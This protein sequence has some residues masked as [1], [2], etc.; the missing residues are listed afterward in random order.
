MSVD[1]MGAP[2][3]C[4]MRQCVHAVPSQGRSVDQA[5]VGW[6]NWRVGTDSLNIGHKLITE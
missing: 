3:V 6:H 5:V 1:A 4:W 2:G